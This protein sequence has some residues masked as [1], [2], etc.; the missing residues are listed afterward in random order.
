MPDDYKVTDR[1]PHSRIDLIRTLHK[2][3]QNSEQVR[4]PRPK[5]MPLEAWR[6]YSPSEL[7]E[8]I[9]SNIETSEMDD[10]DVLDSL[11]T[12]SLEDIGDCDIAGR[13]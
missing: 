2:K 5:W 10:E 12:S 13:F 7:N 8:I 3:L 4:P 11:H 9:N 6:E 1:Q